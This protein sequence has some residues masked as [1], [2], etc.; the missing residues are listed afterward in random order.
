ME[1]TI[2]THAN[3][4]LVVE[5][6]LLADGA[7]MTDFAGV[8]LKFAIADPGRK[9]VYREYTIGVGITL[10]T[11][12]AVGLLRVPAETMAADFPPRVYVWDLQY[13]DA[14]GVTVATEG[15]LEVRR[16]VGNV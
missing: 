8:Q 5:F 2:V 13:R 12:S 14:S 6:E 7:A 3:E 10:D 15:T 16:G 4:D 9:T 1:N 11:V